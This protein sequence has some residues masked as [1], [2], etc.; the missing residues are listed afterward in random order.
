MT[1]IACSA[2]FAYMKFVNMMNE[3]IGFL[4]IKDFLFYSILILVRGVY[5]GGERKRLLPTWVR[6]GI[7]FPPWAP[8]IPSEL[9]S[10][11]K[12]IIEKYIK[13]GELKIQK[14]NYNYLTHMLLPPPPSPAKLNWRPAS[15]RIKFKIA[16]FTFTFLNSN[17]TH[18]FFN[19]IYPYISSSSLLKRLAPT[20]ISSLIRLKMSRRSF[21]LV[22][23]AI[24]NSSQH[25]RSSDSLSGFRGLLKTFLYQKSLPP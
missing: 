4:Q 22:A 8:W 1:I 18:T 14:N 16:T 11:G 3:E 19:L 6:G 24:W 21:S 25:I 17:R 2:L 12:E 9:Q 13:W 10:M 15:S 7:K 5:T 20:R 23:P